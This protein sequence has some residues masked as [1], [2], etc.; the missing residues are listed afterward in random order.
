M[1]IALVGSAGAVQS[2]ASPLQGAFGQATTAGNLLV[3][4]VASSATQVTT[5]DQ[6]WSIA[7]ED[8][9]NAWHSLIAY[10]ANCGAAETA[11]TFTRSGST[12]VVQCAEFSGADTT[13]PLDQ[14]G[15]VG[16]PGASSPYTVT[17]G[18][19]DATSGSLVL[20]TDSHLLSKSATC[21]STDTLNNGATATG[22]ANNDSTSTTQHYRFTYGITTGNSVADND[23][24]TND[25]MSISALDSVIASFQVASATTTVFSGQQGFQHED[26]FSLQVVT[27][28]AV[29]R[30]S[31]W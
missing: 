23:Q 15:K 21:T 11:P 18:G 31:V 29:R 30:S 6:G 10:K 19:A 4:W 16:I 2:G 27:L 13:S 26:P 9:G 7:I 14:T 25:S 8:N 24:V 1:A 12:L 3:A 28:Q 5:V 17:A 22:N 20:A